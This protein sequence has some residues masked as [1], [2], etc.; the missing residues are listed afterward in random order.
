MTRGQGSHSGFAH[1]YV[2]LL[3]NGDFYVGSTD[4]LDRRMNDHETGNGGRTTKLSQ[5]VFF[6]SV[7]LW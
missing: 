4:D 2:L 5:F 7:P 1:T 6:F 3:S